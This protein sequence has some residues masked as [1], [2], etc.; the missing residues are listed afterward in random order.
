MVARLK[1]GVTPE[2]AQSEMDVVG[3]Q[4]ETAYPNEVKGLGIFV[5]PLE[6]HVAGTVRTPLFVL[7]GAVGFVLLIAYV[8]VAGL[9]LSRAEAR[10]RE[11][12]VRSALGASRGSLVRQLVMEAAAV[13]IAAGAAGL[14]AAF[15]GMRLLLRFAP[16]DLPRIDEISLDP[17][18]A[19]V[20]AGRDDDDGAGVWGV[21]GVARVARQSAA[22]AA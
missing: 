1:P 14:I 22:G 12:L 6:R 4:I 17:D 16:R 19:R 5:N 20:R 7:L 21:A 9:F 3:K 15:I 11:I 18:G 10:G 13:S 2:Q 8:N